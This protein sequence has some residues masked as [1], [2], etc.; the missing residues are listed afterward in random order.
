[1]EID[2]EEQEASRGVVYPTSNVHPSNSQRE[3]IELS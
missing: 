2:N 1:M 3:P